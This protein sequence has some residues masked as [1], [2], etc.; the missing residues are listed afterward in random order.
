MTKVQL[1]TQ[2]E[3]LHDA[4]ANFFAREEISNKL[5]PEDAEVIEKGLCGLFGL[6]MNVLNKL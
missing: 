2:I 4:L 6:H 5:T 3:A 1:E